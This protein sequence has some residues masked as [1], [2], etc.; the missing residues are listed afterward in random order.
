MDHNWFLEAVCRTAPELYHNLWRNTHFKTAQGTMKELSEVAIC[1][2]YG[3]GRVR[4]VALLSIHD[5]YL[6]VDEKGGIYETPT[7][8]V[9]EFGGIYDTPVYDTG[10]YGIQTEPPPPDVDHFNVW[11]I[12]KRPSSVTIETL[13]PVFEALAVPKCAACGFRASFPPDILGCKQ[14]GK[15]YCCICQRATKEELRK[16]DYC[17]C[18]YI[19]ATK[20]FPSDQ[21]V[22]HACRFLLAKC[23]HCGSRKQSCTMRLGYEPVPQFISVLAPTL[24][25]ELLDMISLYAFG[26]FFTCC[27]NT[28]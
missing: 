2:S 26:S 5:K 8:R 7:R 20:E 16:F 24:L 23:K 18:G 11:Y 13:W 14:S 6:K 28:I 27:N 21:A 25:S 9:M 10:M 15:F 17:I 19:S 4:S 3:Y 22:V 1:V 12:T